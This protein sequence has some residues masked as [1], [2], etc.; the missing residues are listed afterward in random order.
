MEPQL[1]IELGDPRKL[2]YHRI[3]TSLLYAYR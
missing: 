1:H 2:S 3:E